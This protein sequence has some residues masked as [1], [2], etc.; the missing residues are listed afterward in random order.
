MPPSWCQ[1]KKK[2]SNGNF[3]QHARAIS[4]SFSF[5]VHFY[6]SSLFYPVFSFNSWF[7]GGSTK[8]V[9]SDN[10]QFLKTGDARK[11]DI[12]VCMA[13]YWLF[14]FKEKEPRFIILY[15]K[16][17]F[18]YKPIR[19]IEFI[20][21]ILGPWCWRNNITGAGMHVWLSFLVTCMMHYSK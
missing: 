16:C 8:Q 19:S 7:G 10:V 4:C 17:T 21:R 3:M 15:L 5:S 12:S 9:G 2:I 14:I 18:R 1:Q 13:V 6:I 11:L 20:L